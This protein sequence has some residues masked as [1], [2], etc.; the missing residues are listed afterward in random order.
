M[1]EKK[2]YLFNI[3]VIKNKIK[4]SNRNKLYKS[5]ELLWKI[6]TITKLK[7]KGTYKTT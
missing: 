1:T 5:P 6:K 2:G 7:K 3:I 4:K